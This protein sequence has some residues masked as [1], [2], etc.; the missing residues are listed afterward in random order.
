LVTVKIHEIHKFK[1]QIR[2]SVLSASIFIH[3]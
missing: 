1:I 2:F 3:P